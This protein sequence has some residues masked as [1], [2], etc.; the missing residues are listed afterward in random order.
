[1]VRDVHLNEHTPMSS[2]GTLPTDAQSSKSTA[3]SE[4]STHRA[5]LELQ[6]LPSECVPLHE[7]WLYKRGPSQFSFSEKRRWF[8]LCARGAY[9][10]LMYFNAKPDGLKQPK[11][12][13]QLNAILNIERRRD[14]LFAIVTQRRVYELRAEATEEVEQWMNALQAANQT[15]PNAAINDI[16]A[17]GTDSRSNGPHADVI[18]VVS[19]PVNEP[20]GYEEG[21][22]V[23]ELV[24]SDIDVNLIAVA[25]AKVQAAK[26]KA[27]TVKAPRTTILK[28]LEDVQPPISDAVA[29]GLADWM[30]E[31]PP[32]I[33]ETLPSSPTPV[34]KQPRPGTI[35]AWLLVRK[36]SSWSQH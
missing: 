31:P 9:C 35:D 33:H 26:E 27:V 10:E 2:I 24:P 34:T 19:K 36:W 21:V 29:S 6:T 22:G 20:D 23:V 8:L 5:S 30:A 11:G 17:V 25:R 14:F 32:L 16:S 3:Y 15:Q 18:G 12:S 13:I 7:G 1:M 28:R 4:C